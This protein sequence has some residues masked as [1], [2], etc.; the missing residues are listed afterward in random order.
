MIRA[1]LGIGYGPAWMGTQDWERGSVVETL[2]AW[3]SA[4]HS[5]HLVK[6][7]R[8][9]T[10]KRVQAVQKF[11]I[12]STRAWREGFASSAAGRP[13]RAGLAR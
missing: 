1:G 4:E 10:P 2:R 13:S 8:R 9:M 7:D 3:R 5:L 12:D 6:L 11:I